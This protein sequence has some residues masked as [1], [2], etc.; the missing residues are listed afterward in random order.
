MEMD[1]LAL[2]TTARRPQRPPSNLFEMSHPTLSTET[3]LVPRLFLNIGQVTTRPVQ[4]T[5]HLSI[6]N[7]APFRC[8]IASGIKVCSSRQ[9]FLGSAA[10]TAT[11]SACCLDEWV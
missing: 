7:S 4:S 11:E 9:N 5:K 10:W 2:A 3:R 1:P 8:A 6:A